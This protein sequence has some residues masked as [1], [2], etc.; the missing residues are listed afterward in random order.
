MKNS[1]NP[2]A[3]SFVV[4][5]EEFD[6]WAI[7]FDPDRCAGFGLNPTGVYLWKLL[8]G[9]N[10]L[11][12]L[13]ET[14]HKVVDNVPDDVREHTRTFVDAL[15]ALGLASY[16]DAE[17]CTEVCSEPFLGMSSYTAPLFY[18][19]P[20]LVIIT[21][22]PEARGVCSNHG[23]FGGDCCGGAGATGICYSGTCGNATSCDNGTCP[24]CI[25]CCQ[26]NSAVRGC[27]G[28]V[29]DDTGCSS[30]RCVFDVCCNT[31]SGH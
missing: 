10:D 22:G 16:S 18:E 30:G 26:G 7:L 15:V 17:P 31:G 19:A 3:N 29:W 14:M 12:A 4:L 1:K 6:D 27:G 13:A 5:R 28:G 8:D 24:T 20:R 23:S 25:G 2:L 11:D 9:K 21:S